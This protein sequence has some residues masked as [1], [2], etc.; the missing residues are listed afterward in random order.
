[1]AAQA[2]AGCDGATDMPL[3]RLLRRDEFLKVAASRRKCAKPGLV[4]Q[5]MRQQAP[6]PSG[7]EPPF[8]S[9]RIGFTASRKVGTAVSR[10]RARRRLRAAAAQ[11]IPTQAAPGHDYVMIARA[12]TLT[13]PFDLLI[14]DL[15]AALKNL[16]AWRDAGRAT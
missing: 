5:V 12:G 8:A 4:L 3:G 13:R 11:V 6:T 10:N 14:D 9:I 2:G 16:D 7:H 1:M 15:R